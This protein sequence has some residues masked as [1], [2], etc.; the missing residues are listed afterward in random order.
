MSNR[1]LSRRDFLKFTGAVSAGLALTACG[2]KATELPFPTSTLAPTHELPQPTLTETITATSTPVPTLESLPETQKS[3]S[4]F[5][6]ALKSTQ[7]NISAEQI[8]QQGL[9]TKDLVGVDGKKYRVAITSNGYVLLVGTQNLKTGEWGWNGD[10][11]KPI[12]ENIFGVPIGIAVNMSRPDMLKPMLQETVIANFSAIFPDGEFYQNTI[13]K[14]GRSKAQ[15]N[16][17]FADK[18]DL[19]LFIHPGFNRYDQAYLENIDPAKRIDRLKE[20]A[21]TILSFVKKVDGDTHK[22][23]TYVTM[24]NEPFGRYFDGA[25]HDRVGWKV[26][27]L[28]QQTMGN[29]TLIETYILFYEA[30][31]EQGLVIGKDVFFQFSEYGINT[32]NPKYR[33]ALQEFSIAKTEIAKR[34]KIPDVEVMFGLT[35]EQRYDENNPLDMPDP[36]AGTGRVRP[37]TEHELETTTAEFSKIVD[38]VN[39]TEISDNPATSEQR[40]MRFQTILKVA[41]KLGVREIIFEN[42]LRFT[43]EE[44]DMTY[45]GT[46]LFTPEY[47]K[48]S[49]YYS[50][51][52]NAFELEI[53]N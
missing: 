41:K 20:R 46:E 42:P 18:N 51:V 8:L 4:E 5:V 19:T 24:F 31:Q 34:L 33:K 21:R 45:K 25:G 40:Q 39:Y 15:D 16:V 10:T 7:S 36:K 29:D 6:S 44:P 47:K 49:G 3:V 53:Q 32:D 43:N 28:A 37:P 50:L 22:L 2:V 27:S 35:L 13:E 48:S 52:K 1:K 17:D 11:L 9:I 38:F 26:D 30:A 14:W 12:V 23:P